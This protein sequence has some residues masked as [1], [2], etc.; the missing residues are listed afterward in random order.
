M[1]TYRNGQR[2][3]LNPS[4]P[5]EQ[6]KENFINPQVIERY[7]GDAKGLP[8]WVW[9]LI[10][11]AGLLVIVGVVSYWKKQRYV[12]VSPSMNDM[13][14]SAGSNVKFGFRFY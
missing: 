2:V 13:G 1:Y 11:V 5:K 7:G 3:N 4:P 14:A 8:I 6:I 9:V 12:S 10:G